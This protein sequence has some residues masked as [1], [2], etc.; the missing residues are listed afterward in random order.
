[1]AYMCGPFV[2]ADLAD[3]AYVDTPL[4]LA[5]FGFNISAP[6]M[7][8]MC[9]EA[10]GLELGHTF[11]DIGSGCGHMTALGGQL[12]GKVTFACVSRACRVSCVSCLVRVVS[13]ACRVWC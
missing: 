8:A 6:H 5:A 10:L 4:R 12:V 9:L 3:Q 2:P 1:M 11:L 7:Y 13:R